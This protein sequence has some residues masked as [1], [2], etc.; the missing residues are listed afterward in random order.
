MQEYS[1]PTSQ[2]CAFSV[3]VA[4]AACEPTSEVSNTGGDTMSAE[5]PGDS[6]DTT[7]TTTTSTPDEPEPGTDESTT[8]PATNFIEEPDGGGKAFECDTWT[9]NCPSG[10]KCTFWANDGGG[11]WNA[12]R[13]VEIDPN[14]DE[15]GEPC[16]VEDNGTSG[17]DTCAFGAMCWDVDPA[18]QEGVCRELCMGD[19][20][21]PIC[22]DPEM[23]CL[24]RG[25]FLCLPT[26]CP[27]EQDC[28]EIQACYPVNDEFQCVPDASGKLGEYG[29]PCEFIN[30][31]DPGL[32][33]L[34]SDAIPDC[35]GATGCCTSF[36][37]VG[38]TSCSLLHP[39]LE[40][41]PWYEE[42][43]A[44]PGLEHVG[45]CVLAE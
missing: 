42:G 15:A 6:G 24:G 28:D 22:S 45:A 31:C 30:V 3:L 1:F 25:P 33:C 26:C 43:I 40:C 41:T 23:R 11:S 7:T 14:P 38:S 21:N 32:L 35:Q 29:D 16:T 13:C 9:Q 39:D 8:E 36:C 10:Q 27:L 19:E 12:T 17:V 44:P 2:F 4:L 18:N 37:E 5:V 34:G 20:S